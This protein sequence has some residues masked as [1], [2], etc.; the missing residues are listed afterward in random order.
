MKKIGSF[1][2]ILAII[3]MFP[4]GQSQAAFPETAEK[5]DFTLLNGSP[6][7]LGDYQD[8]PIVLDWSASWCSFCKENQKTF[9]SIYNDFKEYAYFITISYGGSGDDL[10]DVAEIQSRGNYPWIFA[11]DTEDYSATADTQNADVWIL[12]TDL[13]LIHSWN[14]G[15]VAKVDF[16]NKLTEVI[17]EVTSIITS[18]D[19]T[20]TSVNSNPIG[21]V[22]EEL[23]TFG[24]FENP[25]FL[26]FVVISVVA[27]VF[28]GISKRR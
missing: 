23:R 6:A 25:L 28:I 17:G 9:N 2:I 27:V 1:S 26:G 12:D 16:S 19:T 11:L 3:L 10:A 20:I 18:G 4:I 24:L 21:E 15:I 5:F 14:H 22:D 7:N 13:N 8:K